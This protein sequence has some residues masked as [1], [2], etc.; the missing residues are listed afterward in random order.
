MRPWVDAAVISLSIMLLTAALLW[1]MIGTD[2]GW[3]ILPAGLWLG[4]TAAVY[5]VRNPP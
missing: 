3:I 4:L 1:L 5:I 2:W